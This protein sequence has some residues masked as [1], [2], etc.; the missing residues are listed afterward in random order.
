MNRKELDEEIEYIHS[1]RTNKRLLRPLDVM[2][3]VIIGATNTYTNLSLFMNDIIDLYEDKLINKY[4]FNSSINDLYLLALLHTSCEE[5][6]KE[7]LGN[8]NKD[9]DNI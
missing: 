8:E 9:I 2:K 1:N 5:D 4:M 7:W 3:K 6:L